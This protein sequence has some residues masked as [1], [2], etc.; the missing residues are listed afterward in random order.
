MG[1]RTKLGGASALALAIGAAIAPWGAT[2]SG[3]HA[4]AVAGCVPVT[5][6]EAII[7]DSGSM[8]STDSGRLRFNAMQLFI[9]Q[10]PHDVLGAVQFGS[11]ASVIFGPT[12]VQGN[13]SNMISALDA[14]IQA[15]DGSTNY[16]DA[17]KTARASNPNS[18]ARIFITDGGQ[19]LNNLDAA[20][21]HRGS[22]GPVYVIGL[23][24]GAP[25]SGDP[26]ADR[27]Q[28]IAAETGGAYFSNVT[29]TGLAGQ[30]N[31]SLQDVIT[32]ISSI[33]ACRDVPAF[34]SIAFA[35][36][37]QRRSSSTPVIPGSTTANITLSW[38]N[39]SNAYRVVQ[40][41]I[42]KHGRTI[43]VGNVPT[44]TPARA[45]A[46][47]PGNASAAR[48]KHR[49]KKPKK[50]GV[51]SQTG[52]TFQTVDVTKVRGGTLVYKVQATTVLAPET[53]SAQ[54]SQQ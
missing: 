28:R 38:G 2:A 22:G 48:R 30:A 26:D 43:A 13:E 4:A 3:G 12:P 51:S 8:S 36:T 49:R 45:A 47:G 42:R 23:G 15:D 50:L 34:T 29:S 11:S 25:G 5:S 52:P 31:T 21:D 18:G 53:I 33:L 46:A 24:I 41:L 39:A 32:T 1:L 14:A 6:V 9:R 10:N 19:T 16:V 44:G 35:Q 54:V 40:V 20:N 17:F 7:D 27:L 37:G